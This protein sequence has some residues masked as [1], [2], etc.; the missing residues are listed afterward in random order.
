MFTV[1]WA[2]TGFALLQVL[3]Y[4]DRPYPDNV[5]VFTLALITIG[6]LVVGNLVGRWALHRARAPLAVRRVALATLGLDV[7]VATSFIWLWAF[8]PDSALWAVLFILP[9]EGAIKFQLVGA[10]GAWALSAAL[11]TAREFWGSATYPD[12]TL[13]WNSITFRMGVGFLI[14]LVAGYMAR[15]LTQQRLL[16]EDTLEDVR[17]VDRLR[18]GLVSTL[19]HD[20][21]GPLT[22]IRTALTTLLKR[23]GTLNTAVTEELLSGAERQAARMEHLATDLLDLA[24]LEHGRLELSFRDVSLADAVARALSYVDRGERVEVQ[25]EP[26]LLVRAD[27]GRLEQIVVNLVTNALRYGEEPFAVE[28]APAD[29]RVVLAVTD[30]GTGIRPEDEATL[31]DPFRIKPNAGSVG[32]G[33]AVVRGLAEA[34]GGGVRYRRNHPRGAR[35]EVTIPEAGAPSP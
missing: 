28:A 29:G 34:H 2:A 26:E 14:A 9:L 11:Y 35:F 21:R 19:A 1:R 30:H 18:A 12:F 17:R 27:P 8:D 33:L 23:G 20:V 7:L 13:Q 31:F 3:A 22:A 6:V 16:V 24:R 10:L 32:F 25:I 5:P 15:D 4:D